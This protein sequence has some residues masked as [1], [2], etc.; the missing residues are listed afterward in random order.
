M[1]H[2]AP[3]WTHHFADGKLRR[4]IHPPRKLLAPHVRPRMTVVDVGC[5]MGVFSLPLA[6]RVG[7]E[8]RVVAVDLAAKAIDVLRRRA[9]RAGLADRI[10]A[11]TCSAEN[12][13]LADLAGTVGFVLA[14][15]M[16]HEAPD[17]GRFMA[18]VRACMKPGG[19]LLLAEPIFHVSRAAYRAEVEAAR[20]AGL[21]PCDEPKVW[22]SRATVFEAV[23]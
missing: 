10:A 7:S 18:Q 17:T 5:G 11:R 15:W 21:A 4:W 2:V 3:V 23:A 1:A 9:Q 12:L 14:F 19:K 16:A 20:S 13:G 8:G 6:E 22:F